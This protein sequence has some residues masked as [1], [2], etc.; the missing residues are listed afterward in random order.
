MP[1]NV[2]RDL[3]PRDLLPARNLLDPGLFCQAVY[4]PEHRLVAHMFGAPAGE[5]PH[6]TQA[7]CPPGRPESSLTRPGGPL[8]RSIAGTSKK[9]NNLQDVCLK[10]NPF[11]QYC[12]RTPFPPPVASGLPAPSRFP[13]PPPLRSPLGRRPAGPPPPTQAAR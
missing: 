4:G 2:W 1:E 13:P 9:H 10:F 8:H 7:R 5:E 11:P 6:L 3:P 12:A